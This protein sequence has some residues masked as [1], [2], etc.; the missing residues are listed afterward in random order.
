MG[1]D[2]SQLDYRGGTR[3]SWRKWKRWLK[4]QTARLARRLGRRQ[5]D[6]TPPRR[7]RGWTD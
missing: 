2:H 6:D 7:T 4:K 5:L 1:T 3:S